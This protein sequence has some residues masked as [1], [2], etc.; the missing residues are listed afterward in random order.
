MSNS[1]IVEFI[2]KCDAKIVCLFLLHV[3]NHLNLPKNLTLLMKNEDSDIF[4]EQVVFV[5]DVIIS[6]LKNEL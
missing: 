3:Y 1:I 4:F 2:T 5:D 6:T